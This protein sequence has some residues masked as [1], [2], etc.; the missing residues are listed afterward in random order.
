MEPTVEPPTTRLE[1]ADRDPSVPGEVTAER[2]R[3]RGLGIYFIVG[4]LFGILLTKS[5]M[6][7]WFRMQEMFRFQS[8]YMYGAFASA[9]VT[10]ATGFA[11]IK[12]FKLRAFSGEE[13]VV[14]PK[15]LGKG[16]RYWI[17]GLTFGIGWAF[18]GACPGPLFAQIG[19]GAT[20]MIV[21]FISAISGA[22]VY[23]YLRPKLPH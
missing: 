15:V 21:A 14:P 5:E 6:I 18:T 2:I 19:S 7:S 22:W 17:G 12:R 1:H 23:G 10:A 3:L 9:I 13:I 8:F 11:M 4:I 20:V 16:Y